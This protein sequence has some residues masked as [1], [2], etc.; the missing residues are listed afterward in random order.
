[1]NRRLAPGVDT[2][3]FMTDERNHYVSL[4]ARQGGREPRRRRHRPGARRR[5]RRAR[6]EVSKEVTCR[7]REARLAPRSD[8]AVDHARRHG[9][10]GQA[11]GRGHR[12]RQLRRRRARLRHARRTSRTPRS[13]ALDKGVGKYTE[14]GGTLALRKAIAAELS[15]RPQD[16]DRARPDVLVSSGAKHSLYNLFMA[17]IDPGDEVL[18][19]APYWVSY[20]DMVMLA[21]GRPVI[22][23]TKAEDD[24]AVHRRAGRRR[25]ARRGRARSCSTT[26][27]NPTGAVYTTRAD[28]GAR[29]RSSSRRTCSSSPTTST[30]SSST[31]TPSTSRSPRSRPRSPSARS[32]ST[33]SRRRTR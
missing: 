5:R 22:L 26:R 29:R 33:A 6:G 14:V 20:P 21:G 15:A 32:S 10:G 30:A 28:R 19:P 9:Q 1:M 27:R 11:Q 2:V 7:L 8:Q 12:R 3:F 24:F 18:I 25:D 13:E 16:D 31:A 23:E 17:L 4:V